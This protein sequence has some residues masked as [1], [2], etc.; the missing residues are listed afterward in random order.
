MS[1]FQG[2][3]ITRIDPDRLDY[4]CTHFHILLEPINVDEDDMEI[5]KISFERL[6]A[7]WNS[8]GGSLPQLDVFDTVEDPR[9][10]ASKTNIEFIGNYISDI[11]D[12]VQ[13]ANKETLRLI[14]DRDNIRANIALI[15]SEHFGN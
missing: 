11:K 2:F 1:Q 10:W 5:W 3:K 12:F 8:T 4:P 9:I 14:E 6:V 7:D 13:K 15:N